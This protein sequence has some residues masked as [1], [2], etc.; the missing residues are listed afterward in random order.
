MTKLG[1]L[2][3]SG[4]AFATPTYAQIA[5]YPAFA[6][7]PVC[8]FTPVDN[9][10][11]QGVNCPSLGS[12]SSSGA[13]FYVPLSSLATT[14][15]TDALAAQQTAFQSQLVAFETQQLKAIKVVSGGV[16]MASALD[17]QQPAYGTNN[18]VGG[19]VSSFNGQA[20]LALTYTLREKSWDAGVGLATSRYQNMAKVTV[21]YSW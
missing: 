8:V 5:G 2:A 17:F 11:R 4:L 19:G 14:S 7:F 21:G 3:L 13:G 12:I 16:A 18:R 6:G 1:L 9:G 10:T 15:V 20:G